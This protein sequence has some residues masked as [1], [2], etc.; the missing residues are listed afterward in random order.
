MKMRKVRRNFVPSRGQLRRPPS[1]PV[2]SELDAPT[3]EWPENHGEFR[4]YALGERN[5]LEMSKLSCTDEPALAFVTIVSN[6]GYS[7]ARRR[8]RNR[9]ELLNGVRC[10]VE[11]S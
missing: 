6:V 7:W 11:Q 2:C 4:L 8:I 9:A 10:A 1:N 5:S 3:S